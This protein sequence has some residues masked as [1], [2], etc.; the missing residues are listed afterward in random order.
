M[1]KTLLVL[2]ILAGLLTGCT[3]KHR[4]LNVILSYTPITYIP[5]KRSEIVTISVLM[6]FYDP[7]VKF[8][9]DFRPYPGLAEYWETED[10]TTWVFHLRKNVHFQTGKELTAED[11]VYTF[12]TIHNDSESDYRADISVI[13]DIYRS[14]S[15]TVIFKLNKPSA[16]FLERLSQIL[17]IQKNCNDSK[18]RAFSCGTG[19]LIFIRRDS[20]GNIFAKRN[21]Y[22]FDEKVSFDRVTFLQGTK[23]CPCKIINNNREN[24]YIFTFRPDDKCSS[25]H[26]LLTIPGP[27]NSIRYIGINFKVP[28]LSKKDFRKALYYS[29]CREE[30]ADSIK[31]YYSNTVLPAYEFA[32]PT[33]IGYLGIKPSGCNNRD[34]VS[35][36]LKDAGYRNQDIPLLVSKNR[37]QYARLIKKQLYEHG[38]HIKIRP[39]EA[40]DI[41]DMVKNNKNLYL[42][43]LALIPQSI[44]IYSTMEGHFH[45]LDE[46]HSLGV[47]NH[48]GY[49]NRHLDSLIEET[50]SILKRDI[51][52]MKLKQMERIITDDLP[53]IPVFYEGNTYYLSQ[54]LHWRPRIDRIILVNEVTVKK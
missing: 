42:Y 33:Q 30:I 2:I 19:P 44:D 15:F 34:L 45:T 12:K 43:I 40:H 28:L 3:E 18:L 50:G 11:V 23:E 37:Y 49:S 47:K 36:L 17:I 25:T 22:Y 21:P 53:V 46:L 24:F 38:I 20:M 4:Q 1:K 35:R 16:T 14:D 7:L 54:E 9:P 31:T 32:L 27:L 29:I 13:K 6:N 26:N 51:R 41:F 48:L 8:D 52:T 5:N 39:V 10:S